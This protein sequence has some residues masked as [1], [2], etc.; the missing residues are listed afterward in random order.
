MF[1]NKKCARIREMSVLERLN[2]GVIRDESPV[3][4]SCHYSFSLS[5]SYVALRMA[6]FLCSLMSV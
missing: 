5:L 4:F 3:P 2:I 1:N 6:V